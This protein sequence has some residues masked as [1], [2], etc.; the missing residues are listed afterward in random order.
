MSKPEVIEGIEEVTCFRRWHFVLREASALIIGQNNS[1]LEGSIMR[2]DYIIP[3]RICKRRRRRRRRT[4]RE[5]G[6]REGER[7][8]S[9]RVVSYKQ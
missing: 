4:G 2:Q 5:E 6:E 1:Y 3:R 7:E 9:A 8:I